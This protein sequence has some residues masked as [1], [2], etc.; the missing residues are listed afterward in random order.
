MFSV[1]P[2]KSRVRRPWPSLALYGVLVLSI[3]PGAK[4]NYCVSLM[5]LSDV[6]AENMRT[7]DEDNG[8]NLSTN[9]NSLAPALFLTTTLRRKLV[10]AFLVFC[11]LFIFLLWWPQLT[12]IL[13]VKSL[14]YCL[15]VHC[16]YVGN[17]WFVSLS[18]VCHDFS[19][20]RFFVFLHP[21]HALITGLQ[22]IPEIV[23]ILSSLSL[24]SLLYAQGRVKTINNTHEIHKQ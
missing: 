21:N 14:V 16:H 6:T 9:Y 23:R 15:H 7:V 10:V 12:L 4:S 13:A 18:K 19:Y 3:W 1:E 17:I 22:Y 11:N 2:L 8:A 24:S 20:D 5:I